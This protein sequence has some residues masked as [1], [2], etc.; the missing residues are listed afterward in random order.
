MKRLATVLLAGTAI[1]MLSWGPAV[2][3]GSAES[4]Y[5]THQIDQFDA[6]VRDR[7]GLNLDEQMLRMYGFGH[8]SLN[9]W[10]DDKG[11]FRPASEYNGPNDYDYDA[12]LQRVLD[13]MVDDLLQEWED[14]DDE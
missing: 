5:S 1:L 10:L 2:P 13:M 8:D 11:F 12:Y 7:S 14:Y 4:P 6:W 9:D 3:T